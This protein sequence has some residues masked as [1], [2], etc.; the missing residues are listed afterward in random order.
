MKNLKFLFIGLLLTFGVNAFAQSNVKVIA[1][2]TKAS[3]CPVCQANGQRVMMD[4]LSKLD[5]PEISVVSF[6]RSN[7]QTIMDT[8][9]KLEDL[10]IYKVVSKD[11]ATGQITFIDANTHKVIAKESVAKSNDDIRQ[12]FNKALEKVG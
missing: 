4:V 2:V 5:N 11:E 7:D 9:A 1:V 3:W 10:G 8:K 6:D 12:A